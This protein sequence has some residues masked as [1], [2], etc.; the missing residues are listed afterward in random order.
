VR[1]KIILSTSYGSRRERPKDRA[2]NPGRIIER[3]VQSIYADAENG[4][5]GLL[6]H[7]EL[8]E[9]ANAADDRQINGLDDP[10]VSI[11]RH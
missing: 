9:G 4:I 1:L 2:T 3:T 7:P 11:G 8:F 6:S 5:A 10:I